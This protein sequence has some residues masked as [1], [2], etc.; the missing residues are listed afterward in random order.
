MNNKLPLLNP[1]IIGE[2]LEW[3]NKV[4]AMCGIMV[5]PMVGGLYLDRV[6]GT[7]CVFTFVG[8][9]FGFSGGMY[10]LLKMMNS[11]GKKK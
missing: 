11:L 6:L 5:L 1:R 7:L 8:V 10:Y 2:A 9:I 3:T 4:I